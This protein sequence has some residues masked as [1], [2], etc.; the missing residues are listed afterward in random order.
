MG[1][2]P[3]L[4]DVAQVIRAELYAVK[5]ALAQAH[6]KLQAAYPD[7]GYVLIGADV[8]Y[9]DPYNLSEIV[10]IPL[11]LDHVTLS[12]EEVD[13][14]VFDPVDEE[15]LSVTFKTTTVLVATG[16]TCQTSYPTSSEKVGCCGPNSAWK[17][18]K[19]YYA[20][21]PQNGCTKP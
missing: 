15:T 8:A 4:E 16:T 10:E 3:S 5:T 2:Q 11:F 21:M 19:Y 17:K 12:T 20:C 9:N 1:S 6:D 18:Y 13:V 7:E 14:P